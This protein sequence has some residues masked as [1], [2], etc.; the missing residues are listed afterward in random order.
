MGKTKGNYHNLDVGQSYL[1]K[2]GPISKVEPVARVK[3]G[4]SENSIWKTNTVRVDSSL[5]SERGGHDFV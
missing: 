5:D 1:A 3:G 2:P 4:A